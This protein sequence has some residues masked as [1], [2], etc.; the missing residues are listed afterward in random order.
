MTQNK[1]VDLDNTREEDQYEIMQQIIKAGHCP[2]CMENLRKYHTPPTIAE[3]E[4]WLLT[5][6]KWPYDHTQHHLL[7][8]L[9]T[10]K[11]MLS[12]LTAKEGADLVEM[13]SAAQEHCHAPGGGFA[14][15]FGDTDYSAGTVRHLHAQFIVPDID[16][17]DFKPTRFKI[18][19]D[20][21][22]RS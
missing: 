16:A 10:H 18:G 14:M 2:F 4:S 17:P 15:R 13:L 5:A 22:K 11:E 9:K 1:L 7:I 20:K 6:N 3:N 8:I 12:E 19:K 21:E